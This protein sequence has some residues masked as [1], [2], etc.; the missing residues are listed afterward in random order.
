MTAID[1]F[2]MGLSIVIVL[3]VIRLQ[4][5]SFNETRKKISDLRYFF[6]NA[7]SLTL[8]KAEITSEI[9]SSKTKLDTLIKSPREAAASEDEDVEYVSLI[10]EPK[11]KSSYFTEVIEDTN[12]YLCK[13]VGTSA[14]FSILQDICERKIDSLETQISSTVNVPLYLG[15]GGTFVG[16]ITGLSGIVT[17]VDGLFAQGNMAPL[18]NLLFGVAFAMLASFIGL[19]LMIL[20]SAFNYKKAIV[21]CDNQKNTYYDFI[22]RELMPVLSNSMASSLNSLKSVLGEFIGK[23]GQNLDDYANSADLLNDNIE[24]QHLLLVEINKMNQT[25]VATQIAETFATLKDSSCALDKFHDYQNSL[26]E[27]VGKVETAVSKIDSVVKSFDDFA[28]S[29]RVVIANQSSSVDLQKQFSVAIEKHFPLES[30][31]REMWRKQ[32]DELIRDAKSTSSELNLQ[33]Q[34]STKYIKDFVENNTSVFSS[35][36]QLNGVLKA[37]VDYS[38]VQADCYKDLKTEI[39]ALKQEQMNTQK[40]SKSLNADLLT[41]VREMINALKTLKN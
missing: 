2:F 18:Q 26:N 14:D 19:G 15:L 1:L 8:I 4:I 32:F 5:K 6:A 16:I 17:N 31:A 28:G 12:A 30:D 41:A 21:E 38:K 39:Q 25:Q 35:M 37:L 23:F 9:L 22:R 20:N 33:L 40:E 24:K 29:L 13:N 34:A 3:I 10:K 27:T 7:N 11:S 36:G